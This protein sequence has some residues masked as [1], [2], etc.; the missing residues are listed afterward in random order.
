LDDG[1][2]PRGPEGHDGRQ[3]GAMW[4]AAYDHAIDTGFGTAGCCESQT[5]F[6]E[7]CREV[8]GQTL[9]FVGAEDAQVL[10]CY[11]GLPTGGCVGLLLRVQGDPVSVFVVRRDAD[12]HPMISSCDDVSSARSFSMRWRMQNATKCWM[13]SNSRT[14][15]A[16]SAVAARRDDLRARCKPEVGSIFLS[17]AIAA[18]GAA[19]STTYVAR[20]DS[21]HGPNGMFWPFCT[22]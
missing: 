5:D 7:K 18:T 19:N 4:V 22:G 11:S 14:G 21:W 2:G 16:T 8:C 10:G 20:D 3:I 17:I 13:A 6:S 1:R 15:R 9:S 12:P